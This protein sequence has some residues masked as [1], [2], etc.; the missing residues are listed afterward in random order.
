MMESGLCMIRPGRWKELRG[1]LRAG[2]SQ[3]AD[4]LVASLAAF[5][6]RSEWVEAEGA[7]AFT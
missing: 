1:L 7:A 3:A 6:F 5:R 2:A 4:F